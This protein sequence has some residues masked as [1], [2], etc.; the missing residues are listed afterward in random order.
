MRAMSKGLHRSIVR[1]AAGAS[2]PV[3]LMTYLQESE[4]IVSMITAPPCGRTT[5]FSSPAATWCRSCPTLNAAALAVMA[6]RIE[7]F[8]PLAEM[9]QSC[10]GSARTLLDELLYGMP[11]TQLDDRPVYFGCKCDEQGVVATLA[12]L[13]RDDIAEIIHDQPVVDLSCDYCN[14]DFQVRSAQLQGLLA[15]S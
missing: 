6:Q 2:V 8:P 1:P 7:D 11:F 14:R 13:N 3:A 12:T 15:P 4:Q 5:K 10:H 9:L